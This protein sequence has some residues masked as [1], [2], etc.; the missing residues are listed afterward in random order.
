MNLALFDFDGTLSNKDSY[1]LFTRFLGWKRYALGCLYLSPRIIGFLAG[2]YSRQ[3]LKEDFLEFF[4][5]G[6]STDELQGLAQQFCDRDV[7]AI[8][9][10]GALERIRYHQ[11]QGDSTV[12]VSACP[13]LILEP[14]C[15]RLDV[16]IIATE[17]ETDSCRRSTGKIDGHNCW[18][19]EK[20]R[21][22]RDRYDLRQYSG[23][24]AYGDSRGDLPMLALADP[25]KRF[26]KPFR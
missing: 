3:S 25:D 21:R 26:F 18:G 11:A 20:V 19:E 14:W 24:Y 23:I 17:L 10:P 15:R 12:V 9:R 5:Q 1:L 16:E 13:R 2:I 7:P 6:R 4:Y 22:I 8:I